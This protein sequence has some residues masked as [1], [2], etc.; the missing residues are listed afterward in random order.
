MNAELS[1]ITGLVEAELAF[2]D[3]DVRRATVKAN[4]IENALPKLDQ[5]LKVLAEREIN[6]VAHLLLDIKS[7]LEGVSEQGEAG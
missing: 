7:V 2:A 3:E 6:D 1:L 5:A 4:R